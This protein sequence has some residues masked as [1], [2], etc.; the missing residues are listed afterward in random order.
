VNSV[1]NKALVIHDMKDPAI[2]FPEL[3]HLLKNV[4]LVNQDPFFAG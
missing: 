3:D 1:G 2:Q 4:W